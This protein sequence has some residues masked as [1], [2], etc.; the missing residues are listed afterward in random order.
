[1][2]LSCN[3]YF[4]SGTGFTPRVTVDPRMRGFQLVRFENTHRIERHPVIGRIFNAFFMLQI[5]FKSER[6][7]YE[8]WKKSLK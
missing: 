2:C 8:K 5:S 3:A 6:E 1:M 4:K 7:E